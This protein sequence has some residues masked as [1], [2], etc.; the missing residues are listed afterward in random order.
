[1]A[2]RKRK[3]RASPY[4][5]YW[6]N[7]FTGQREST[8]FAT[9]AEARREDS[10]IKHRLKH[11]RDF[12]RSEDKPAKA[13][14]S[15]V[16]EILALYMASRKMVGINLKNTLYHLKP[17]SVA[18]ANREVSSL[19]RRDMVL[20]INDQEQAGVKSLTAHRRLSILRAALSWAAENGLIEAN[21]LVGAKIPKGRPERIA[22]PSIAEFYALMAAAP[23]HLQRAL[24]LAVSLGVRVGPS[25][26]L[27][28]Q[29]RDVDIERGMIRV[30]SADKNPN[31]PFRDVPVR[32]DVLESIKVWK[33]EDRFL[34][35]ETIV[36]YRGQPINSLKRSWK[37]CKEDAGITRRLRP[38]DMR[39]AFAT[40][41]LD[42]GA[43]I[44]AV[45]DTMG[46]SDI[47]M[48]LKHYQHGKEESRRAAVESLPQM[49]TYMPKVL[50]KSVKSAPAKETN[51]FS[52][53]CI[54]GKEL[55]D[56]AP[57]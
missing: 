40:Y 42:A 39:H 1:M 2:I 11:E 47:S 27:S 9:L 7:P 48:I 55:A 26:L 30:W 43:D 56:C 33:H 41:A 12:F 19:E 45:A 54:D 5:V 53:D 16:R 49:P 24:L 38:Y 52:Q 57:L 6:N 14:G 20:F 34:Q 21:P 51:R 25:E 17:V 3:D 18:F 31:R 4:Q 15:T 29:W 10:L 32:G 8:S 13:T 44:K 37:T 46:H 36:H 35:P 50:S 28:L 22:P 23:N